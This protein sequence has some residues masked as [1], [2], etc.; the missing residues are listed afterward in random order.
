MLVVMTLCASCG[1]SARLCGSAGSAAVEGAAVADRGEGRAQ[2]FVGEVLVVV[3]YG[4]HGRSW[5]DTVS[6]ASTVTL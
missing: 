5:A 3:A 1:L 4:K 2:R 6:S